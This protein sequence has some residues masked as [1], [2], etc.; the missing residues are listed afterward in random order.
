MEGREREGPQVT[1]EPGPLRALLRHC[2]QDISFSF[3]VIGCPNSEALG[4]CKNFAMDSPKPF[5]DKRERGDGREG[6][7]GAVGE[8]ELNHRVKGLTSP[9]THHLSFRRR[10][11]LSSQSLALVLTN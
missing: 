4:R 10:V 6:E 7:E 2:F 5:R 11:R 1:V 3:V 8:K 9:S